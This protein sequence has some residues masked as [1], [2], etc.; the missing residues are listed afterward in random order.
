[1]ADVSVEG[2]EVFPFPD[3]VAGT[4]PPHRLYN[5]LCFIVNT[6]SYLWLTI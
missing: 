1:M 5:D 2:F 3:L 6:F 4:Q